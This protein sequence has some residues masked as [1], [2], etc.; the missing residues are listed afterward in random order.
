MIKDHLDPAFRQSL[1]E[2][3]T[4]FLTRLVKIR[5]Y[6]NEELEALEFAYN[7][8][9]KIEGLQVEKIFMDNSIKEN[10][11]WCCGP[12][13]NN[14]YTGHY[15]IECTWK[16]TGE[17]DPFYLCAHIDTVFASEGDEHLLHPHVEGDTLYGL[18]ACDD[19]GSI[20]S[21]YTV[22]RL[23]SHYN[24]RLPF[25]VVGHIVVEEEIGGNGALAITGRPLKG[26]AAIVLE[27]SRGVIEP[28]HRC[29]LWL[30]MECYGESAHTAAMHMAGLSGYQLAL[31]A[32]ETAKGVHDAYREELKKNPVKYYEDY[33][34]VFNVGVVRA[35]DW[36][37]TV[38]RK[39]TVMCSVGVLPPMHNAE[40]RRRITEA[41]EAQPEL[42]G[43]VEVSFVFDRDFAITDF[44]DPYVLDFQKV[45]QANG[46]KGD[47]V[48]HKALSDMYF[49]RVVLDLPAVT[50]GPGGPYAHSA[51]EQVDYTDVL[52]VGYTIYDFLM[53][54]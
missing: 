23:L 33:L 4:D 24:I 54:R 50:F 45:V 29:G 43:K 41:I 18:G 51:K 9:S 31:K 32:I 6:S 15:N 44:N 19:K 11:L 8:F 21:I 47:I 36:P 46:F 27:P 25:D 17:K 49:Y 48:S 34:P 13:G 3:V 38:P 20:A 53:T 10:P 5:S 7:A 30:K 39:A 52:N 37:S 22:F 35:G 26:Q 28:V 14:D 16:G 1:R 12:V 2:D 40:M 42:K